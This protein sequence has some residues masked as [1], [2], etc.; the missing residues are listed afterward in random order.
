ME[1][2]VDKLEDIEETL[3][4]YLT[5]DVQDVDETNVKRL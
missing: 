3:G 2:D 4:I 1:Q 5:K